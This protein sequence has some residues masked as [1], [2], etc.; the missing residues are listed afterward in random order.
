[1]KGSSTS[2][3]AP[4]LP[5]VCL[6]RAF[7][8][9]FRSAKQDASGGPRGGACKHWRFGRGSPLTTRKKTIP[10]TP[11]NYLILELYGNLYDAHHGFECE[12]MPAG[13]T[14]RDLEPLLFEPWPH[15]LISGSP[16]GLP[17]LKVPPHP[18][19][20]AQLIYRMHRL[21]QLCLPRQFFRTP[22]ASVVTHN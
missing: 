14:Y 10:S 18:P 22:T 8:I 17:V 6:C 4:S 12:A 7:D 16:I 1:M 5:N 15:N 19:H 3:T 21:D 11:R 2:T 13:A 9:V 20:P